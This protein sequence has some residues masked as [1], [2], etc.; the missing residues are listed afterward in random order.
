MKPNRNPEMNDR[1]GSK[2]IKLARQMLRTDFGGKERESAVLSFF[3]RTV[4]NLTLKQKWDLS[5]DALALLESQRKGCQARQSGFLE[6]LLARQDDIRRRISDLQEKI[7][8]ARLERVELDVTPLSPYLR[9]RDVTDEVNKL[10][11]DITHQLT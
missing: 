8:G 9:R 1:S 2:L 11:N 5:E 4:S 7:K 6:E 3:R 10:L